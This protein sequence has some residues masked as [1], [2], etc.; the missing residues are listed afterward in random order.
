MRSVF[1]ILLL[2]FLLMG[3]NENKSDLTQVVEEEHVVEEFVPSL[4]PFTAH[5]THALNEPKVDG[6]QESMHELIQKYAESNWPLLAPISVVGVNG[7]VAYDSVNKVVK[8]VEVR[9]E[10]NEL[11]KNYSVF[12]TLNV[13]VVAQNVIE[14]NDLQYVT[15][16]FIGADTLA[17]VAYE[18]QKAV[19]LSELIKYASIDEATTTAKVDTNS[20]SLIPGERYQSLFGLNA[21]WVASK[22]QFAY[23]A[24][25]SPCN[26]LVYSHVYMPFNNESEFF[27]VRSHFNY[28]MLKTNSN[29]ETG[30][31]Q[32]QSIEKLEYD[33]LMEL[34]EQYQTVW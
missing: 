1:A 7:I 18:S 16:D 22:D 8:Q 2:S 34:G 10:A 13:P 30:E 25:Y 14:A 31:L 33:A 4:S 28:F 17:D 29:S 6:S 9:W 19:I 24:L 20:L 21:E 27:I 12:Y 15:N 3:C 32:V 26:E 11:A 23:H 5:L